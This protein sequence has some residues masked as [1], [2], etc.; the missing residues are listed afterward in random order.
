MTFSIVA[1]DPAAGECGVAVASKFLSAGA[2]VPWARGSVG[3]IATQSHANTSYGPVGLDLLATGL[4]PQAV[5]DRLIPTRRSARSGSSICGA[6]P[7]PLP[8]ASVSPG[9]AA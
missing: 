3:A 7:Q 8:A 5:I 2:V 4:S 9:S 6:A 1:A